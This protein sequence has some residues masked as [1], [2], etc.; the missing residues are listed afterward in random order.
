MKALTISQPYASLIASGE[1]WIEN[2]TWPTS[3]R[4]AVAIHAGKGTQY[5]GQ[6][7]LKEYH[8]GCVIAIANLTA[9]VSAG[10]LSMHGNDGVAQSLL[11]PG[12]SKT[13]ADALKH[14]H[15]EGPW[16]WILE[17]IRKIAPV[18]CRGAQGLWNWRQNDAS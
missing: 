9:C 11:I 14:K 18:P 5:L 12:T 17:D 2:R 3:Y 4:G 8:T 1:K 10:E 6:D 16:C 7:E 15:A 13:W